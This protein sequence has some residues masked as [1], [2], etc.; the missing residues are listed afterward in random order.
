MKCNKKGWRISLTV[1]NSK[2]YEIQKNLSLKK[3]D[4][5]S[6]PNLI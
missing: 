3:K 4:W 6:D 1:N 5:N 2:N